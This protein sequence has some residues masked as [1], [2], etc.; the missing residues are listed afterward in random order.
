MDVHTI[1]FEL[2][3]GY[4]DGK[5]YHKEVTMR[6]IKNR[7]LI[8]LS[9]DARVKKLATTEFNMPLSMMNLIGDPNANLK[10]MVGGLKGETID[11]FKLALFQAAMAEYN[12]IQ[13]GLVVTQ[14][15]EIE[16][17]QYND[18]IELGQEDMKVLQQNFAKLNK[19]EEA[20][21]GNPGPLGRSRI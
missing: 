10:D 2:P 19:L 20:D 3:Q 5:K 17:P 16:D 9:K 13:F 12:C 14:L 4:Y 11:P 1:T 7:D 18:F 6:A 8:A 21:E 15:G